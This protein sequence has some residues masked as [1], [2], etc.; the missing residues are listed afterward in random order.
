MSKSK[1]VIVGGVAAG[2]SAAAKARRC[3]E[4]A[5]IIMFE[6]GNDISYATCGLPYYISRIIS[7][8]RRLLVT[9]AEFFRKRFNVDVRTN[10]EVVKIDRDARKISV[11]DH[12]AGREYKE[13][14]DRLVLATGAEPV[15]PPIPGIDKD[16]V[17]TMK[18]L[19][20]TDRIYD[21]INTGHPRSAV[22]IGGG[23]IGMEMAENFAHLGM[24]VT[25][26]EFM[27][28][29]LT[30]LDREM[31]EIVTS[32]ARRKGVDFHLSEKVVRLDEENGQGYVVTDQGRKL[33][34]D[35]VITA[36]GIR[37]GTLLAQD[38]GLK[39]GTTGGVWVDTTMQ[40]SD[41]HIWAAGDCVESVN[42]VTGKPALVPR[43]SAAN[44][45]GRAAGAN[46][47]GRNITVKGFTSTVI[48]K[49]F[50]FAVG[51][52]GLSEQEA[53]AAGY[54]PVVTYVVADHHAGYYPG[55]KDIWI[56]TVAD[57]QSGRLLGAQAIGEEGV[58]KRIDVMATAIYNRMAAEDLIHLDLAYAPPYSSARDPIIVAGAQHQNYAA[59]DWQPISPAALREKIGTGDDFILIDLRTKR[60]LQQ[61]GIIAGAIH[62]P[63]DE[64]RDRLAELD[65]QTEI[66]LYCAVGLRSYLGNR[67]LAMH[68][69]ENVLT[70]TGG[71][72][73]WTYELIK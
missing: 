11:V 70:M 56:K 72:A 36:V 17:F 55:A 33:T 50:D 38:A 24:N 21:F 26:V 18:T 28:Q 64:L 16:F 46:A 12:K 4:E 15:M 31:A 63:I 23:L 40:T 29:I 3:S 61:T 1:L 57:Q 37:P 66:V 7:N 20:D 69:Y 30:F 10:Q 54:R 22:I 71:I 47:M 48:V 6:K 43:G 5:E 8:R 67:I 42:L 45:Q 9:R 19:D 52:T 62:I 49:V 35:I 13:T 25:V 73:S 65:R 2:A 60:E 59:G 39:I 14:Y 58:D 27:P 44:K 34:A 32:H 53:L 68:G 51:K 41:S